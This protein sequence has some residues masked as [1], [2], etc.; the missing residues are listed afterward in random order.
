MRPFLIWPS[1][2]KNWGEH[3]KCI[4]NLEQA[5]AFNPGNESAKKY[6][7]RLKKKTGEKKG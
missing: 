5:V 1:L 4:K 2:T 7:R 3:T 6:L